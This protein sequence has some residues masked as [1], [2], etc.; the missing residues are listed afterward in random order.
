M[1]TTEPT[2][3]NANTDMAELSI[4]ELIAPLKEELAALNHRIDMIGQQLDWLCQ[5]TQQAFEAIQNFQSSG[6]LAK[7]MGGMK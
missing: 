7:L 3:A 1:D 2:T 4:D 5:N 6:M